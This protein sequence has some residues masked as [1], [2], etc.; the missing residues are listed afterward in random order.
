[1][2]GNRDERCS[3][4]EWREDKEMEKKIEKEKRIGIKK[5]KENKEIIKKAYLN[6]VVKK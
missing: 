2:G 5:K 6:E 4:C 1:M 3:W